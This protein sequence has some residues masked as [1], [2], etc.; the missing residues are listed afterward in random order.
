M[1]EYSE[2]SASSNRGSR[3]KKV[4]PG[5]RRIQRKAKRKTTKMMAEVRKT[6]EQ[7]VHRVGEAAS[8]AREWKRARQY[9]R[10]EQWPKQSEWSRRREHPVVANRIRRTIDRATGRILSAELT[11]EPRGRGAEDFAVGDAFRMLEQWSREVE[12]DWKITLERGVDDQYQVGEGLVEEYY[13]QAAENGLGMARARSLDARWF[14]WDKCDD[15]QLEDADYVIH[16]P[17]VKIGHLEEEFPWL[18]GKINSDMGRG[19]GS[20]FGRAGAQAIDDEYDGER[21]PIESASPDGAQ[22]GL[23]IQEQLAYRIHKWEKRRRYEERYYLD[24]E[25]IQVPEVDDPEMVVDWLI[26]DLRDQAGMG[27]GAE[28]PG[29]GADGDAG[30]PMPSAPNGGAPSD[31]SPEALA[32][33]V[34]TPAAPDGIAEREKRP[35][36]AKEFKILDKDVPD[37]AAEIDE[38]KIEIVELWEVVIVNDHL[39]VEEISIYDESEGGHGMYPYG[40]FGHVRI[41]DRSRA[42]GEIEFLIGA[43]DLINRTLSRWLETLFIGNA[44]FFYTEHGAL[45]RNN[46]TKLRHLGERP[47]QSIEGTPGS[48]PPA[49]VGGNPNAS[50]VFASGAQ[51]MGEVMDDTSADKDVQKGGSPYTTSGR[52]ILALQAVAELVN[53]I[54]QNH[55]ES[56]LRKLIYMRMCNLQQFLRGER[57]ARVLDRATDEKETLL[58]GQDE[59]ELV[60]GHGLQPEVDPLTQEVKEGFYTR[61]NGDKVRVLVLNDKE[62]QKFDIR[63][64]LDTSKELNKAERMEQVAM[65]WQN[66]GEGAT[67]WALMQM[68][69]KDRGFLLKKQEERDQVLSI[70]AP[71][72][73]YSE[74][75]GIPV[76]E[77]MSLITQSLTGGGGAP[78]G[79]PPAGGPP[80]PPPNGQPPIPQ[81]A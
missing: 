32:Q 33:P 6:R 46:R 48:N 69:L 62:Y 70:A 13:D 66:L 28:V 61:E 57:I 44:G 15:Q 29:P 3:R 64:V 37:L 51:I 1:A 34:P 43:Q 18:K 49:W 36:N 10:S 41:P 59:M 52:G 26:D 72:I 39:A 30:G 38:I 9:Y 80:A 2:S 73:E 19:T 56:A 68:D 81:G 4:R 65:V 35:L 21:D 50:Q 22:L 79:G 54:A 31:L 23:P 47:I 58:V 11:V 71:I 42:M 27:I 78:A 75:S 7:L 14:V 20:L 74:E 16:F 60:V 24:G 55:V 40:R 63:L 5:G 77:V 25:L 17:P 76:E 12:H 53:V 67:E 45:D 8:W